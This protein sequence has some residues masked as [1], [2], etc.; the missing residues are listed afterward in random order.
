MPSGGPGGPGSTL[1]TALDILHCVSSN[2][3]PSPANHLRGP[4]TVTEEGWE[5]VPARECF[6]GHGD[7]V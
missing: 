1:E 2:L 3:L 5:T 6:S 7:P 4:G